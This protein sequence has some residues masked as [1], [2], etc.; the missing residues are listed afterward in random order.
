MEVREGE[1]VLV[2]QAVA[3]GE[4]E[5]EVVGEEEAQEEVLAEA[6]A[7]AVSPYPAVVWG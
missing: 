6:Q 1:S 3:E 2:E 4:G 7:V 5:F